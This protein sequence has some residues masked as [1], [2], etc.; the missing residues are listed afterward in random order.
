MYDNKTEKHFINFRKPHAGFPIRIEV[1]ICAPRAA[2]VKAARELVKP[3]KGLVY[4]G[5]D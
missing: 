5:T 2:A 4:D 1:T 3:I